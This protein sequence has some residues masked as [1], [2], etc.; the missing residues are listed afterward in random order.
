[1]FITT[2]D[3]NIIVRL[4]Y[5]LSNVRPSSYC[6]SS[7]IPL[8]PLPKLSTRSS[9]LTRLLCPLFPPTYRSNSSF[10]SLHLCFIRHPIN[11]LLESIRRTC[12]NQRNLFSYSISLAGCTFKP[13]FIAALRI[14]SSD[15]PLYLAQIFYHSS[16]YFTFVFL[17]LCL[18]LDE[19]VCTG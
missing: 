11:N 6:T 2:I 19:Y 7:Y 1:M 8:C 16:L 13:V 12:P 10:L 15:L 5:R 18:G 9:F 3:N 14:L 17:S 4:F